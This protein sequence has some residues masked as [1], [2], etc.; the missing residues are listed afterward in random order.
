[1]ELQG[2]IEKK[3]KQ[4]AKAKSDE[5]RVKAR[6]VRL[7]A[8]I[9]EPEFAFQSYLKKK[10]K[11]ERALKPKITTKPQKKQTQDDLDDGLFI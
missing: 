5:S 8:E 3:K 11:N 4:L 2:F 7:E 10:A 6:I 1:M 9:L